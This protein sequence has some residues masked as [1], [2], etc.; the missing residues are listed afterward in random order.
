MDGLTREVTDLLDAHA[1]NFGRLRHVLLDRYDVMTDI[2]LRTE[3]RL[4]SHSS[5]WRH[6]DQDE[7]VASLLD[8][9]GFR[10]MG[11]TRPPRT[12]TGL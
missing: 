12:V 10:I 5:V 3:S 11:V 7:D 1:E 6:V 4:K 8:L 2:V 9:T